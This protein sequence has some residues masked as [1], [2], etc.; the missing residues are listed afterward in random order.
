MRGLPSGTIQRIVAADING[1]PDQQ[2]DSAKQ[3]RCEKPFEG[4]VYSHGF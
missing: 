2:N 3:N 4:F 1:F